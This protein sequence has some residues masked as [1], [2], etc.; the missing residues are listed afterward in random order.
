MAARGTKKTTETKPTEILNNNSNVD[1][2][3]LQDE[4]KLYK[5]QLAQMKDMISSL[6]DNKTMTRS[7]EDRLDAYRW[8]TLVHLEDRAD[9]LYTLFR[10][11]GKEYRFSYL[12]QTKKVKLMDFEDILGSNKKLF[13]R[14]IM[15]VSSEDSDIASDYGLPS[16]DN[17]TVNKAILSSLVNM[18]EEELKNLYNKVCKTHKSL[19]CRKWQVGYYER[20]TDG[21]YP[22]NSEYKSM[23]KVL[24]L[25]EL[26]NGALEN[27]LKDIEDKRRNK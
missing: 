25:N 17:V 12:G 13:D 20:G 4:L 19:I 10:A 24:M 15:T 1:I 6:G 26:S 21:K 3:A 23:G 11:N 27:V 7:E 5:E 16:V 8:I 14:L 9:G 22:A 18:S 2:E